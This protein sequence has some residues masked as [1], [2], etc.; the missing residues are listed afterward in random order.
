M[1]GTKRK[2]DQISSPPEAS[3]ESK[4]PRT[5]ENASANPTPTPPK[6]IAKTVAVAAPIKYTA[7]Q[8]KQQLQAKE[9]DPLPFIPPSLIPEKFP[10]I[11][12]TSYQDALK[13]INPNSTPQYVFPHNAPAK[14][15]LNPSSVPVR[16][17]RTGADEKWEDPTLG[18]WNLSDYRLFIGDLGNDVT[19]EL[20]ARTFSKYSSFQRARVVRDK[21]TGKTKGFGFVSFLDPHDMASAIKEMN[22]KYIGNRPCKI[23]KSKWQDRLDSDRIEKD[24][25]YHFKKLQKQGTS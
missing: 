17:F 23:T 13:Q 6:I 25:N 16:F 14:N 5:E 2:L 7:Q 20:L 1:E 8:R 19:D 21:R 12:G 3:K 18:D 22:G 10:A 15:A 24:R 9:S 4:Q 11:A